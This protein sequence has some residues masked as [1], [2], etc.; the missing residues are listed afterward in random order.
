MSSQYPSFAAQLEAEAAHAEQ[1]IEVPSTPAANW[2]EIGQAD[3]HGSDYNCERAKL[4]MGNLT[5]DELAN[6]AF[7]NYDRR[8]PIQSVI[9]GR[10]HM[11]IAWMTAVKDRIR[12]LSRKLV[13]AEDR[14]K[15]I[16]ELLEQAIEYGQEA[17]LHEALRLLK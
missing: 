10:A 8:P 1:V 15:Q 14:E 2:R 7:M 6:G 16:K 13:A 3:P 9:S 12:W 4:C 5:D 11:P 17:P